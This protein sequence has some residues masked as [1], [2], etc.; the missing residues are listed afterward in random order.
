AAFE[1][2]EVI[3]ASGYK[4]DAAGAASF[5]W[6][7]HAVLAWVFPAS[8]MMDPSFGKNFVWTAAPGSTGGFLTEI[9]RATPVSRKADELAV[10]IYYEPKITSN[11]SAFFIEDAVA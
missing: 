11:I 8:S 1:V 10:H 2:D 5:V 3:V 6:G 7:K 9:G 4:L